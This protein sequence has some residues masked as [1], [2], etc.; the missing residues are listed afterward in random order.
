MSNHTEHIADSPRKTDPAKKGIL[1]W[2][3]RVLIWLGA[4]IFAFFA[5]CVLALIGT[6]PQNQLVK[7]QMK[8]FCNAFQVGQPLSQSEVVRRA[9]GENY[10]TRTGNLG[11]LNHRGDPLP[12]VLV[13]KLSWSRTMWNCTVQFSDGQISAVEFR[14]RGMAE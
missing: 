12:T 3:W 13:R 2:L 8:E 11:P 4:A 6:I 1:Q 14:G 5:L 9:H 10:E 7:S